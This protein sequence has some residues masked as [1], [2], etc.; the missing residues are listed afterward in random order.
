MSKRQNVKKKGNTQ[1][2]SKNCFAYRKDGQCSALKE[3]VCKNGKNCP[4]Y[5]TQRE[6]TQDQENSK[7]RLI[8]MGRILAE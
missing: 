1:M 8:D 3:L 4:F 5:K 6:Y 2:N 7:K